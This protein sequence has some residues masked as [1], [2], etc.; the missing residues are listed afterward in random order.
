MLK[1]KLPEK[2]ELEYDSINK[3]FEILRNKYN[4]EK[5]LFI[6]NNKKL[7]KRIIEFI[8]KAIDYAI[9]NYD[10][11]NVPEYQA[12]LKYYEFNFLYGPDGDNMS[13]LDFDEN[14]LDGQP[15]KEFCW[16]LDEDIIVPIKKLKEIRLK[17]SQVL[18]RF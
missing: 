1:I 4:P 17:Y 10:K 12:F 14:S 11:I 15:L 8:I 6:P 3:E 18:A 13:Y 9:A 7:T 5:D 2:L 16:E